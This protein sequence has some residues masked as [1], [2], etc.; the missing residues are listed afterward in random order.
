MITES[1]DSS[2][3]E[4]VKARKNEDAKKVDACILTFSNEIL[5]YVL[6]AFDCTKIGDIYS[7]SQAYVG[8]VVNVKSNWEADLLINGKDCAGNL[9]QGCIL[10][11]YVIG[12][13]SLTRCLFKRPDDYADHKPDGYDLD[14]T[15]W[16]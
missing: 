15:D 13:A 1:F 16:V 8:E 6:E 14:A 7:F 5:Q 12:S 3:E 11:E 9:I 4:I 2:T 10:F